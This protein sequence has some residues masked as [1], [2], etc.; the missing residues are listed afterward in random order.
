MDGG[1]RLREEREERSNEERRSLLTAPL[2]L[3]VVKSV[4]KSVALFFIDFLLFV[5]L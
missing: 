4:V 3:S 5:L 1:E 2:K